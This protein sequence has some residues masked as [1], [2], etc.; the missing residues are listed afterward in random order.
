MELEIFKSLFLLVIGE[1]VTFIVT[2]ISFKFTNKKARVTYQEIPSI[3]MLEQNIVAYNWIIENKG[4]KAGLNINIKITLPSPSTI[5]VYECTPSEKA[6]TYLNELSANS[7]E[8]NVKIP[9]LPSGT[10]LNISSLIS[11]PPKSNVNISVIGDDLIGTQHQVSDSFQKLK[12]WDK[13]LKV[14]PFILLIT[15]MIYS[16]YVFIIVK[17]TANDALELIQTRAI[18]KLH[19]E[20]GN[21]QEAIEIYDSSRISSL[22]SLKTDKFIYFEKIKIYALAK[23]R[24]KVISS[25]NFLINN[26]H[27]ED[28][29]SFKYYVLRLETDFTFDSYR[30][31]KEFL[32]LIE[33]L[34]KEKVTAK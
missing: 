14:V 2:I 16:A 9:N 19:V 29:E 22:N 13:Y 8:L 4:S 18:A 12:R 6:I 25:L 27:E 17:F 34:K 30:T 15:L 20:N 32:S 23:Q 31:D 28:I 33:E 1:I 10:S 24:E 5:M 26:A 3:S 7:N 21:F 11:D